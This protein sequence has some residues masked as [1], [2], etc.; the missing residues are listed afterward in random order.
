MGLDKFPI[1]TKHLDNNPSIELS[2]A[3]EDKMEKHLDNVK[4]VKQKLSEAT[5]EKL[6]KKE[7]SEEEAKLREENIKEI[8]DDLVHNILINDATKEM[9][10]WYRF[11]YLII[12]V[13]ILFLVALYFIFW[14]IAQDFL[15][16]EESFE[17]IFCVI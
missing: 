6:L 16:V 8:N 4:K 14:Y 17:S 12:P 3:N 13:S 11:K 7:I 15:T 9:N 2:H 1:I 5:Q 10:Y